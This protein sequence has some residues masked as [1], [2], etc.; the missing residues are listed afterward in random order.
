MQQVQARQVQQIPFL[1]KKLIKKAVLYLLLTALGIIFIYPFL[2]MISAS[3]KSN[4]E[5]MTS[6]SL[7]PQQISFEAFRNG[8]V[9]VGQHGFTTFFRN[10]F[11]LVIPTVAFTIISS[12][13]VAYGFARFRFRFN[14]ILFLVMISTMMLPSAVVII[15]RYILFRQFGWLNTFLPWI[16]PA[17]FAVHPFFIFAMMQFMRGIPKELDESAVIDGCNTLEIFTRIIL[18]LCKPALF[19]IGIFQFIWTWNDFFNALIY[20]NSVRNFTVMLGLRMSMDTTSAFHWNQIMAMSFVTM[21][22]C[23]VIFFAAQKYF[24]E[25]ISTTGLK[26]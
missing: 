6:M 19:S 17:I 11:I 16:V 18:P 23:I 20:L 21:I 14:K 2:F 13:V 4:T 3:F 1:N 7:I 25:G 24:V 8:W 15:P 22:P 12:S 5:I 26:G 10:T 9:G